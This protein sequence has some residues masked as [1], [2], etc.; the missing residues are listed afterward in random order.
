TH[1]DYAVIQGML[2]VV[3]SGFVFMNL[4]VDIIYAYIDPRI[5]Y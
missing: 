3:A 1:R 4:I 5:R 2:M